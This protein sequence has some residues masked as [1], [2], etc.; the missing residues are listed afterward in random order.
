MTI[1]LLAFILLFLVT[2]LSAESYDS[3]ML[4]PSPKDDWLTLSTEHF[5]LH[6]TIEHK[7]YAQKLAEI[8]EIQHKKI[9]KTLSWSPKLKTQIVVNDSVDF[10]NG[11]TSIIPYNQFFVYMNEPTD[12]DLKD[13]ADFLETLFTH[14]YTH[15]LQIDQQEGFP[16]TLR[17]IFGKS[18]GLVGIFSIPQ[19]FA[20]QWVSEGIAVY[21][22]SQGGYGRSNSAIYKAKMRSEVIKG[23]A[24][25]TDE[26]YEGYYGSRWP[27]GQVY[28]YGAYFFEFLKERYGEEAVFQYIRNYNRNVI[29]W[30]MSKRAQRTTGKNARDLWAEFQNYLTEKFEKNIETIKANGLTEG[31]IVYS[32]QWQNQLLT[33][34]PKNSLFF[35]HYDQK[36]TP[37]IKQLFPD[38][39]VKKLAS[40][41]G[42]TSIHWHPQ[43]GLLITKPE[44]CNNNQLYSDLYQLDLDS[45]DLNR[46]TQCARISRA[47]WGQ[48]NATAFGIQTISGKNRLV[49]IDS[50]GKAT[51]L[52]EL[53]L[54]ESIGQPGISADGQHIIAAV[55][56][57]NTGWNLESFDLKTQHW[58]RLTH[59]ND[60]PSWPV[61]SADGNKVYFVSDHNG[62]IELRRLTIATQ[63]IETLSNSLGF[64]R[65]AAVN[66]H[67]KTWLSE[68]TGKGD[69][70]RQVDTLKPM[71]DDYAAKPAHTKPINTL[72]T[73]KI[74]NPAQHNKIEPYR[75]RDTLRPYGWEPI[76]QADTQSRTLGL[77]IAGHDVLGFHN[78]AL[79][80]SYTNFED[81]NHFGGF[82]SY[83]Y[84]DRLTL[85]AS[86]SLQ[87]T[88]L[89][90][91]IETP[92]YHET[93]DNIQLLAHKPVNQFEWAMDFFAGAAWEKT[94][95][96]VFADKTQATT[97]DAISGLGLS[98]NNVDHFG[99]AITAD[100]GVGFQLTLESFDLIKKR[101]DHEGY[102]SVFQSQGNLRFGDNQ[103]LVA[104]LDLG[105]GD[106]DG[107]PFSLGGNTDGDETLGGITRLGR[108]EFS[109]RGYSRDAGLSGKNFARAS[110]AWHF[111]IANIYNGLYIPPFGLGK[112][113]GNLFTETGDAWNE[114]EDRNLLQSVGI[115]L[116]TELLIG[117]DTLAFPI[118]FGFA[119]GLD[120][121]KGD[122]TAYIRLEMGLL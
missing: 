7:D 14:E 83:S 16:A 27:F 23:L 54:G 59:N 119:H 75:V 39:T 12:G 62:Q 111:P 100:T 29:P 9:S 99:Q 108:R 26:S 32:Q 109:L 60:I 122:N 101:S 58:T 120:D 93:Q 38:G 80:P 55:K 47:V 31:E 78:W 45:L 73:Q 96:E 33:P 18:Q 3:R 106:T 118:S 92:D 104:T 40:I 74:F 115:E 65:Q 94:R 98:Y 10:S 4:Q 57:N 112:L 72:P 28:L 19:N 37:Q 82:A 68:Y 51:T 114:K 66:T 56:R 79:A 41:K 85:S 13:Q 89:E 121:E 2:P 35:Y 87:V 76:F 53:K 86:S 22:E 25:F 24:S 103:T 69:I 34:G 11:A 52:A 70:I 64:V 20:P 1:R 6:F 102:A 77:A 71:G 17:S 88:Y 46:M 67:G 5:D 42:I 110:L 97:Q 81:I 43:Q 61:Y 48:K 63:R 116:S 21:N 50:A 8:A 113:H 44:V 90:D 15:V 84:N 49:Q 30:R 91:D 105:T 107:K 117:Y 95:N 36:H